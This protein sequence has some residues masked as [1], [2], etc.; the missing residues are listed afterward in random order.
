MN[1]DR[2]PH[3][4]T[5]SPMHPFGE[6]KDK[7]SAERRRQNLDRL[8]LP[9]AI[10]A[11]R[12]ENG[13][14]V[15]RSQKCCFGLTAHCRLQ[16]RRYISHS[17]HDVCHR[18][19]QGSVLDGPVCSPATPRKELTDTPNPIRG[20][21]RGPSIIMGDLIAHHK[22]CDTNFDTAGTTIFR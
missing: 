1:K 21:Y 14:A 11:Q 10:L 8:A 20:R 5:A 15:A 7:P 12:L 17:Q 19:D 9:T 16:E 6:P 22:N 18:A 2:L 3:I 4:K 13:L